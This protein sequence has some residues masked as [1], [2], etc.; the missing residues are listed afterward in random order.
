RR[1]AERYPPSQRFR[2]ASCATH[3]PA[4][5]HHAL[6]R[7]VEHVALTALRIG[8]MSTDSADHA[9]HP[10]LRMGIAGLGL[11]GAFMIR[12][13][14]ITPCIRLSSGMD[15]LERPRDAFAQRFGANV[16]ADFKELCRDQSV[17]AIY[18]ASPHR[19]HASQAIEAMH[20]GK[21]VLV[22]KPLALT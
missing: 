20:H 18:I 5:S 2:L 14:A 1:R 3:C 15:P 21:H 7:C 4:R 22:E 6:R 12:P 13:A 9:A 16:Y 11:A 8:V 17:E 10:P 19:F